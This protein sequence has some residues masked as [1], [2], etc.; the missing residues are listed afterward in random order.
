MTRVRTG[1]AEVY[2]TDQSRLTS[3]SPT[4]LLPT[5]LLPDFLDATDRIY[6]MYIYAIDNDCGIDVTGPNLIRQNRPPTYSQRI[7][8]PRRK[9]SC[10]IAQMTMGSF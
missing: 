10:T 3:N 9:V 2:R 7:S 4:I 5:I 1:A 6:S 8:K